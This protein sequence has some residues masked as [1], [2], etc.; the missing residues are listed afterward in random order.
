MRRTLRSTRKAFNPKGRAPI[1]TLLDSY[2]GCRNRHI[3][4]L[5]VLLCWA[6]ATSRVKGSS[7]KSGTITD[8]N[9]AGTLMWNA[10]LPRAMRIPS[11]QI[12]SQPAASEQHR[13]HSSS[14]SS[15]TVLRL[16]PMAGDQTALALAVDASVLSNR[17]LQGRRVGNTE[18][19]FN[20]NDGGILK[21]SGQLDFKGGPA[22][23][24]TGRAGSNSS[25]G[26]SK[27][28][29]T[30]VATRMTSFTSTTRS[31]EV[32]R[33]GRFAGQDLWLEAP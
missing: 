1:K 2:R 13:S 14:S 15:S 11:Q 12:Q 22:G 32:T 25:G 21:S 6:I 5:L 9:A 7:I 29:R 3:L 4:Q 33:R 10:A 23:G 24:R 28:S 19:R 30:A 17:K 31:S 8:D 16:T 26:A 18:A 20:R 27:P